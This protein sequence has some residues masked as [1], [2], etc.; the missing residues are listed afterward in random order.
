VGRADPARPHG[1]GAAF[2]VAAV[3]PAPEEIEIL[4]LLR[5]A[6][7]IAAL[8]AALFTAVLAPDLPVV[9]PFSTPAGRVAAV[10]AL[11]LLAATAATGLATV[12]RHRKK[13]RPIAEIVKKHPRATSGA[14]L[15]WLLAASHVPV[16][17]SGTELYRL[18]ASLLAPLAGLVATIGAASILVPGAASRGLPSTWSSGARRFSTPLIVLA[19][20]FATAGAVLI[21]HLAF[22]RAPHIQDEVAY[23]FDARVFAAGRRFAAPPPIPDAFPA[24]DWIEIEADRAYGVFP[25]GWPRLLALGVQA[26][27][28]GLVNPI[29]AALSVLLAAGL[30]A[31]AAPRRVGTP[32]A[33]SGPL[34]HSTT[35]TAM[36]T[37]WLV[38]TSPF[39]LVLAAS[40]MAHTA[41][42]LWTTCALLFYAMRAGMAGED[43]HAGLRPALTPGLVSGLAAAL[44]LLTRPIEAV[45]LFA[46]ACADAALAR[47]GAWRALSWLALGF[48]AGTILLG[49]DQAAVTGSPWVPPVERYFERHFAPAT[50]RLGFGPDVGLIWD[51]G[52]PGH[53]PGEALRNLGRN[54]ESLNRHLG[55]WPAG[56]LA[57]LLAFL[58][59]A[60]KTRLERLLLLHAASVV[61]LY[62]LY[63]YH[64]LALG[65]RF[66]ASL[67]PALSL[68]TWRGAAR[69]GAWLESTWPGQNLAARVKAA[70]VVS[71]V[72]GLAIYL[73]L[74]VK[75]EYRGLRGV[76][77]EILHEV[78]AAP[79]PALV[80]VRG[81]RW[82][83]LASAYFLNAPDFR[84]PR[85]VALSRGPALDRVVA[86][87]YPAHG[88]CIVERRAAVR[89]LESDP[90]G[91]P[92]GDIP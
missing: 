32:P 18:I 36:S 53:S 23:L 1:E 8:L 33:P 3:A 46:A 59:G 88:A 20:V 39:F 64:G 41:A 91:A 2:P 49:A 62:T 24:P 17:A 22:G 89:G 38:A 90:R 48:A 87:A 92:A 50:N 10:A 82:P 44:L 69:T 47:R 4:P 30:A 67:T 11:A 40:T 56:S 71:V 65:P 13:L 80:F 43:P 14:A 74:K 72:C 57:L 54:L 12:I 15:L 21:S 5:K 60:R 9:V 26:R 52:T 83:D 28:P 19:A 81:S 76:D 51:G 29:A 37:A 70:L 66:L 78:E 58:C 35:A 61:I 68:F 7:H 73:P 63:W 85:V 45:A 86:A 31:L 16:G 34:A 27:Q 75:T 79:A 25:P 77:D 84:G 6:L 42:T 55:G